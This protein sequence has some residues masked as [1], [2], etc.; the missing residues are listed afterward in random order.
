[1]FQRNYT[2]LFFG[3]TKKKENLYCRLHDKTTLLQEGSEPLTKL[4]FLRPL[5]SLSTIKN[6]HTRPTILARKFSTIFE[7]NSET[8]ESLNVVTIF[9]S[10]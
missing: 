8:F 4:K 1:M 9:R 2:L 7:P 10:T 6:L 5:L 3:R